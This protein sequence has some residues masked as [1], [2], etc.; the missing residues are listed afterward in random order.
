MAGTDTETRARIAEALHAVFPLDC[1]E[2]DA[3][4]CIACQERTHAV[5]NVLATHRPR[6]EGS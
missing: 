2:D 4:D 3:A 1:Y 6:D 5:M